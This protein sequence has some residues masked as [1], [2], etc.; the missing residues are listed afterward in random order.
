MSFKGA[1]VYML[2]NQS[3]PDS[4][5]TMLKWADSLYNHDN[6]FNPKSP[7]RL[8]IPSGFSKIRLSA[9]VKW[10]ST[11]SGL[12]QLDICQNGKLQYRGGGSSIVASSITVTPETMPMSVATAAIPCAGGEYYELR[13]TQSSGKHLNVINDSGILTWFAIEFLE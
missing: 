8:T 4:Q 10:Q 7:T 2:E 3:I 6:S 12:L 1:F 11:A 9:G 13:A 5:P